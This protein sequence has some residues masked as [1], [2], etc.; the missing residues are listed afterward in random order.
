MLQYA[1]HPRIIYHSL[2][3]VFPK[4]A[5]TYVCHSGILKISNTTNKYEKIIFVVCCLLARTRL[6]ITS[7]IIELLIYINVFWLL[8]TSESYQ[9]QNVT[10]LEGLITSVVNNEKFIN[11][12][13]D[14]NSYNYLNL[15]AYPKNILINRAFG[16]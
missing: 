6:W 16:E 8:N 1:L 13:Y 12:T 3:C 5:R 7:M 15:Y 14:N 11:V 4:H 10:T 9:L 2:H